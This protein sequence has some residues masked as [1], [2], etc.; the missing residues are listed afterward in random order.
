VRPVLVINK[1][2]RLITE[3]Q[4]TPLEAYI[5]LNKIL[6]QVNAVMGTF[7][8]ENV[9][10]E[11]YRK[12]AEVRSPTLLQRCQKLVGVKKKSVIGD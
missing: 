4:F 7:F 6:E 9:L 1:I 11:D 10:E 5:H 2:D 3:L 12:K 8:S